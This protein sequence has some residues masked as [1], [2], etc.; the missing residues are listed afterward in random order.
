MSYL[1]LADCPVR[2]CGLQR[3]ISCPFAL[4][5]PCDEA[6][7]SCLILYCDPYSTLD[8]VD[9]MSDPE[10]LPPLCMRPH[11]DANPLAPE[12]ELRCPAHINLDITTCDACGMN[13]CGYGNCVG[14]DDMRWCQVCGV[15]W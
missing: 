12:K 2:K 1:D 14:A 9:N 8:E 4:C 13:T 5:M 7:L 10:L 15:T 11:T 3:S 6:T